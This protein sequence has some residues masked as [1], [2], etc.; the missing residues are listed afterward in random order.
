MFWLLCCTV[1]LKLQPS[2]HA[3]GP[4]SG[5]PPGV[6][7]QG[8][9]GACSCKRCQGAAAHRSVEPASPP[10]PMSGAFLPSGPCARSPFLSAAAGRCVAGG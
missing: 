1:L 7:L 8:H 3:V 5:S 6:P 9:P 4:T 2:G 10:A